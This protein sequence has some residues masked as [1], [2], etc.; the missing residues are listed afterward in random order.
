MRTTVEIPDDLLKQAKIAAV[1]RGVPLKELV[2]VALANELSAKGSRSTSRRVKFPIFSS[3]EPGSMH[4]T[5]ADIR[6]LED[7][8]DVRRHGLSR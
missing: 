7:E 5:N 1:E 6:R 2:R 3:K 8:E 4:L